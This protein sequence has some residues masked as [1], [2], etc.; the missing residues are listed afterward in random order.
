MPPAI[1]GRQ[2]RQNVEVLRELHPAATE[3]IAVRLP[4]PMRAIARAGITDW[5]A[6]EGFVAVL[7]A[8]R[9][10]IGEAPF[11]AW[12]SSAMQRALRGPLVHNLW[13]SAV[14]LFGLEP[15]SLLGWAPHVWSLI[16][17]Q[18]GAIAWSQ[19]DQAPVVTG[20]PALA[21]H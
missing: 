18:A 21:L 17:R 12:S 19:H 10:E 14:H 2:A 15:L 3:R 4:E 20:A 8:A 16:Y 6:L 1:R 5:I 7:D 11:R 13:E 9:E